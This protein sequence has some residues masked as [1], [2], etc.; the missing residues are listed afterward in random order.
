MEVSLKAIDNYS[1]N[2][3]HSPTAA[4]WQAISISGSD[5][6]VAAAAGSGKTAVLSERIA[7]RVADDRWDIDRLL[8]LTFTTAAASSMKNKIEE[9]ITHRLLS[10][11]TDSDLEYL[12]NQRLLINNA[13]ISTI[14][15]FCLNLLKKF[16]YLVEE[17]IKGNSYYLSP[18][19]KVLS[20]N[21]FILTDS[22]NFVIESFSKRNSILLDKAFEIFKTKKDITDFVKKIYISLLSIPNYKNYIKEELTKNTDLLL[23]SIDYDKAF[24]NI[25]EVNNENIYDIYLDLIKEFKEY[26]LFLEDKEDSNKLLK[27][28]FSNKN[29]NVSKTNELI[30]IIDS[31]EENG[32]IISNK[33][34]M[35]I[36]NNIL[37]N[38]KK[39]NTE[40]N[41]SY[42]V[43]CFDDI[44]KIK[45]I[46]KTYNNIQL[47]NKF[48]VEI[49]V[50]LD[51]E[52]IYRKR[53][54]NYLD[55]SDLNHLAIKALES[56]TNGKKVYTEAANYY[57]N[58]FLEIYV[59]EYQDNN[60]LQE[61]IL[62]IIRGKDVNFFRVGD[63]K[64]AI[65]GFRGSSPELFE[66][67]YVS[68][69]KLT[70]L[71]S[72][73]EYDVNKE[74]LFNGD[75]NGICVVLKENF[76]SEENIL[77]SSNYI[78]NRLMY[79]HNAGVSYDKDSA[80]YY[81]SVKGESKIFPT[82]IISSDD[83][84][85]NSEEIME[86]IALEIK[87]RHSNENLSYDKFAILLRSTSNM[88]KY[89][90]IF[91]KHNVPLYY[92]DKKGFTNSHSFNILFNL[93]RFIDNQS[94]DVCLLVLLKSDIFKFNNNDLIKL[95]E[96]K[97][98]TLY[99][100]LLN[101]ETEKSNFAT[102]IL[103]RWINYSYN[104]SAYDLIKT[105]NWDV[106]FVEYMRMINL[107]EI[108]VDYFYN[109]L[110]L[111]EEIEYNNFN[112]SYIVEKLIEV[113]TNGDYEA[114][115]TPPKD[116]VLMSTIHI[117]KGLEYEVVFVVDLDKN[118][119]M[120]DFKSEFIFSKNFGLTFNIQHINSNDRYNILQK[121]Y[122]M[123]VHIQKSKSIEEEIRILYVALTRAQ[124]NLYLASSKE[125]T[126]GESTSELESL[127]EKEQV[128]GKISN[129]KNYYEMLNP[130][131]DYYNSE[132]LYA[133]GDI[134]ESKAIFRTFTIDDEEVV[135]EEKLD[136]ENLDFN[137][138]IDKSYEFLNNKPY[139]KSAFYPAK[140]SYSN[141]RK[142]NNERSEEKNKKEDLVLKTFS[143]LKSSKDAL[144]KGNLIHKL[145]ERIV[146]DIDSGEIIEN[147]VD[148]LTNL[149]QVENKTIN[150]KEQRILSV[151]EY[152]LL[153]NEDDL[154]KIKNFINVIMPIVKNNNLIET[155]IMF[156]NM[157]KI[158]D[159]FEKADSEDVTILQGVIDL[160]IKKGDEYIIIDYKTDSIT[161]KSGENIL[162]ERHS[163]QLNLYANAVKNYYLDATNI[164]KYIYSYNLGKLIEV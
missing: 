44:L 101:S 31:V 147:I 24:E 1:L 68:Y 102:N 98:E 161:K 137:F 61:Y 52:F 40:E 100:K 143:K 26:L 22:I 144:I 59:D 121:L 136:N 156:T 118:F 69:T 112:L 79:K 38:L 70:E 23:G 90:E 106:N 60:D 126:L 120:S 30:N 13:Q 138:N 110:S 57:Q 109:F 164:S 75:Y 122:D 62:N 95:S 71:I 97:G 141:I 132:N 148:Y 14:D 87:K 72:N 163:P 158:K 96:E 86:K 74:Y 27:Q 48:I 151:D 108:E 63:V 124:S 123:N 45:N 6:L 20:N 128:L 116:S 154:E 127:N 50:E 134:T 83:N 146:I 133:S 157:E 111:V 119:N 58:L 28:S 81:P 153:L 89:K 84:K 17:E 152:N 66:E 53:A 7:K 11:G 92:K 19:F 149:R 159:L 99:E 51:N 107:D 88:E 105:V 36:I 47:I 39:Y 76:R 155:E 73:D 91:K 162:V 135:I 65:Y 77:K 43:N 140:T 33:E 56:T 32:E 37:D 114:E 125:I 9:K 130:I 93:L 21:N 103:K 54:N 150:I 15:S 64:Q 160:L 8:V 139:K 142:I 16:Y 104:N 12:R 85:L 29:F 115:I 129:A 55:F 4:Q 41:N 117:S 67:K 131:F 80:L 42:I 82:Y 2:L 18:D 34:L 94:Y 10:Y 3:K 113:K 78:F 35:L 46:I 25:L 49:L 145:F 5:V